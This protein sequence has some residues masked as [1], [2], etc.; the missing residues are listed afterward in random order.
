MFL[1]TRWAWLWDAPLAHHRWPLSRCTCGPSEFVCTLKKKYDERMYITRSYILKAGDIERRRRYNRCLSLCLRMGW[2]CC[3]CCW[4]K[5]LQQQNIHG[6]TVRRHMENRAAAA[7]M[8]HNRD[9]AS[10]HQYRFGVFVVVDR[11]GKLMATLYFGIGMY[12]CG[13]WE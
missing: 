2:C 1:N 4:A 12:M 8:R 9:W 3:C 10:S 11:T 6:F 5:D 13:L 7:E